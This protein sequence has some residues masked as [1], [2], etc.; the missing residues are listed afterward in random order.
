M[1]D[2]VKAMLQQY[3]CKST[4]DYINALKEIIQELAL[5]GLWRAKFFEHAAFYGGTALR[6]LHGLDR[7]SE[8]L[9]FSLL[10]AN[11][12][13]SLKK[14]NQAIKDELQAFGF[15]VEVESKLKAQ[16]SK[17]QSAFIKAGTYQQLIQIQT[18]A[19]LLKTLHQQKIIRIKMEVDTDPPLDFSTEA[20]YRLL[21]I[22]FSVLTFSLPDLFA[23]KLHAVLCRQWQSR[24]KGRD[25]YDL[26][27]YLSRKTPVHLAHLQARLQQSG[28]WQ[29]DKKLTLGEVKKR[30]NQRIDKLDVD[31]A[32]KDISLFIRDQSAIKVW[33]AE[34]FKAII[35]D[36][37]S[38]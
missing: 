11:P 15:V 2:A 17:I 14:Y 33:S 6:I 12:E 29:T 3:A 32:K 27:W 28:H 21:P 31:A 5:L 16:A 7:F 26:V 10:K 22:P 35:N 34:F 13:F 23:G 9:D 36:L 37:T 24:V 18:P 25:W 30:L 20:K 1:N 19:D 38:G 8:D 4:Q